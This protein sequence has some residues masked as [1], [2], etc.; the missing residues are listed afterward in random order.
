M[1]F[2]HTT[3]HSVFRLSHLCSFP[4]E[5]PTVFFTSS[6]P[7]FSTCSFKPDNPKGILSLFPC[8]LSKNNVLIP[9]E[10]TLYKRKKN[11][12]P[13][14]AVCH[15]SW[16]CGTWGLV[17]GAT[18]PTKERQ[19]FFFVPFTTIKGGFSRKVDWRMMLRYSS[20]FKESC[21]QSLLSRDHL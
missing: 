14:G 2:K 12:I 3:L 9:H 5:S 18:G 16:V 1:V 15:P 6:F 21:S 4:R 20:M 10:H 13:L 19:E 11:K 17:S 8:A 7:G